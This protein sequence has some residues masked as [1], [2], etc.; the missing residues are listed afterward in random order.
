MMTSFHAI[1]R[2][3]DLVKERLISVS[4]IYIYIYVITIS[5]ISS[6]VSE[7]VGMLQLSNIFVVGMLR[8]Y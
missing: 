8:A 5:Q 3:C 7:L 1:Q 2:F 6:H 4:Y